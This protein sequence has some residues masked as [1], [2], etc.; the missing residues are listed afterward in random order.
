MSRRNDRIKMAQVT[1]F[2]IGDRVQLSERWFAQ[3]D[4]RMYPDRVGTVTH[5]A[6]RSPYSIDGVYVKWDGGK[7]SASFSAK[8]LKKAEI[9]KCQTETNGT[10]KTPTDDLTPR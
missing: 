7:S 4:S 2:H 10:A 3:N 5:Y 8:F 9:G 1:G 6:S